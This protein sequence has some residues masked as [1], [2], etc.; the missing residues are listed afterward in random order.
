MFKTILTG[1]ALTL[2]FAGTAAAQTPG[3]VANVV[4]Q[5]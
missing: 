1:V 4:I 2:A 3:G 5:P